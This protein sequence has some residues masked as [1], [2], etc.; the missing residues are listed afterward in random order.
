MKQIK[1]LG[2]LAIALALGLT[3][4]GGSKTSSKS[5][6]KSETPSS[7]VPSS[8]SQAPASTSE[9]P[10]DSSEAPVESSESSESSTRHTHQWSEYVVV[11]PA[12]CT[13][14]GQEKRT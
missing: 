1:F 10:V 5:E 9:A 13:E 2:V 11:T 12:T 14:D 4:C 7:V 3:A 8:S 6:S